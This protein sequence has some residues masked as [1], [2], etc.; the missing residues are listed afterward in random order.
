LRIGQGLERL[1]KMGFGG[2]S[3][4]VEPRTKF[5]MIEVEF[6]NALFPEQDLHPERVVGFKHFTDPGPALPEKD[7]AGAL[8]GDGGGA[9]NVCSA[10]PRAGNGL[11]QG[12]EIKSMMVEEIL[13]F[14]GP[15]VVNE[16]PGDLVQGNP[17]WH[18]AGRGGAGLEDP[19]NLHRA[20]GGIPKAGQPNLQGRDDHKE[21]KKKKETTEEA[22][23]QR[24]F[25]WHD[26]REERI[27]VEK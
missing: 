25:G 15:D 3:G 26:R 8:H 27:P 13:I 24:A 10:F 9:A 6:E 1:A 21:R 12:V 2:G 22:S 20:P 4:P 19:L 14:R 11:A 17:F 23:W 16:W 7:G 18:N 5:D